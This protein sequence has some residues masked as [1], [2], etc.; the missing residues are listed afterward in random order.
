MREWLHRVWPSLLALV[1]T[2]AVVLGLLVLTGGQAEDST[3]DDVA[4]D[5]GPEDPAAT[6]T[7]PPPTETPSTPAEPPPPPEETGPVTAAPEVREP[8]GILNQTSINGLAA[9]AKE[10][11]EAG[12][13]EVPSTGDFTGTVPET[14]VYYPDGM[15]AAAEALSAQFPEIGRIQPSFDGLNQSRLVV[16]LV[17]DYDAETAE[18]P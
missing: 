2:V 14:T 5:V 3:P 16:I 6:S 15:K 10:R 4:A 17:E 12:G 11:L 8:V 18:S 1:G 13:W 9:G 7:E